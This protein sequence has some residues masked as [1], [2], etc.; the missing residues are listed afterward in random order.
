MPWISLPQCTDGGQGQNR[1]S[2]PTRVNQKKSPNRQEK[3]PLL[4]LMRS[5]D[6]LFRH[7]HPREFQIGLCIDVLKRQ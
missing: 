5:L 4:T 1:I 7:N 2:Q 6:L 3:Y